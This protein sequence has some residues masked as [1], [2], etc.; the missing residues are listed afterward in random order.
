MGVRVAIIKVNEGQA[1]VI[2]T[3]WEAPLCAPRKRLLSAL[4]P[5]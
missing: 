2:E 4:L 5:S 3:H 1:G